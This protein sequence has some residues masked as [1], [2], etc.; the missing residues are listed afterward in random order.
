M[1]PQSD[2][3]TVELEVDYIPW[4][5]STRDD[6]TIPSV[7]N[8]GNSDP[9][10]F[11][12]KLHACLVRHHDASLQNH[13]EFLMILCTTKHPDWLTN[14]TRAITMCALQ[15]NDIPDDGQQFVIC[16]KDN[17]RSGQYLDEMR[18][19]TLALN[20]P[21]IETNIPVVYIDGERNTEAVVD[22][23]K[24]V[25]N[26]LGPDVPI[27]C[28]KVIVEVYYSPYN[29]KAIDFVSDQSKDSPTGIYDLM[30][31]GA[32]GSGPE[33]EV[34]YIPWGVSTTNG[35]SPPIYNCGIDDPNCLAHKL[36]ACLVGHHNTIV[37]NRHIFLMVLCTTKHPYWLTN[38]NRAVIQ[39]AAQI[40]DHLPDDGVGVIVC[41]KDVLHSA[42][43]LDEMRV[44]TLA[45]DPR[46][47]YED[48]PVVVVNGIRYTEAVYNLREIVCKEFGINRPSVCYRKP[49]LSTTPYTPTPPVDTSST[50]FPS[51]NTTGVSVGVYYSPNNRKSIEFISSLN[52]GL[53]YQNTIYDLVV[54]TTNNSRL[55][56]QFIPWGL[57]NISNDY[58][59]QCL[60]EYNSSINCLATRLQACIVNQTYISSDVI[61]NMIW[62][63]TSH[64]DWSKYPISAAIDCVHNPTIGW[65]VNGWQLI[66]CA[67]ERDISNPLL[68]Q[69]KQLTDNLSPK[70]I[71]VPYITINNQYD[72]GAEYNL[73]KTVCNAFG[74]DKPSN[75]YNF[76]NN[77]SNA[78]LMVRLFGKI[79]VCKNIY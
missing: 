9:N 39:C 54:N 38:P 10:C 65:P 32:N 64:K 30:I 59:Y 74:N 16:A 68:D 23:K 79:E 17:V 75:C 61:F 15:V 40:N 45:L 5:V 58:N 51:P 29:P 25:C 67:E 37:E 76:D 47:T 44:K 66:R 34:D 69:M 57:N 78:D 72:S 41:A 36:H 71:N 48:I 6:T 7:Y 73:R 20:P 8:C 49:I 31:T 63:T 1:I 35:A 50:P 4:G 62:C 55:T 43:Y 22:L 14:P 46:I 26:K 70:L 60:N 42:Q 3:S 77:C 19:K 33:L 13:H 18:V 21:L 27:A 28:S 12:H 2:G 56:V 52:N 11:A 53:D 24:V